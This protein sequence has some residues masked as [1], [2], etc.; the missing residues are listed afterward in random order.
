MTATHPASAKLGG[1]SGGAYSGHLEELVWKRSS[2]REAH[3]QTH[4]PAGSHKQYMCESV[5][6]R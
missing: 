4:I 6:G 5:K 3:L 2:W 1:E